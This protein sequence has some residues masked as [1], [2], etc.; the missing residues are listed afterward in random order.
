MPRKQTVILTAVM[1]VAALALGWILLAVGRAGDEAGPEFPTSKMFDTGE[2]LHLTETLSGDAL[3]GRYMGSPGGIAARGFLHKRFERAGLKPLGETSYEQPFTTVPPPDASE[4][5]PKEGANLVGLLPGQTPGEGKMIVVTAHYDHLG[6]VKDE[7][8][9]G[10]DDNASGAAALTAVAKYMADHPPKHDIV[11]ALVDGEEE[12]F[13]GSRYLVRSGVI[14]LSRV[15]LNINFDMVSRSDVDELYVAG[16]YETPGL[17]PLVSGIQSEAHV[18]LLTGHDSPDLGEDDWT[19]QSDHGAFYEAGIPFLY[20]GVEDHPDYHKPTDDFEKIP[21][22]FFV[23]SVETLIMA[24][25]DADQQLD[26]LDL[27]ITEPANPVGA[28]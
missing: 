6:I 14:D 17:K 15:A 12:G 19:M 9:N 10:A 3:Q 25:E 16:T 8:Y 18:K 7:I 5:F 23:R 22:D 27:T 13:L 20:F 24:V 28:H 11:F 1:A 4:N 2:L 21:Q 26:S